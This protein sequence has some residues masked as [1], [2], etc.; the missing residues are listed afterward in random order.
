M[1]I[2]NYEDAL[3]SSLIEAIL[4]N[5]ND[6]G[7]TEKAV[8]NALRTLDLPEEDARM[9]VQGDPYNI[10]VLFDQWVNEEVMKAVDNPVFHNL[11]VHEKIKYLVSLKFKH[12]HPYKAAVSKGFSLFKSPRV[13]Q[14]SIVLMAENI[15]QIWYKAGDRST[16]FNYYTKRLVLTLVYMRVFVLWLRPTTTSDDIDTLVHD[17]LVSAYRIAKIKQSATDIVSSW[18]GLFRS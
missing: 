10:V 11:K 5:V 3:S 17:A 16:D 9:I 12:M 13:V 6:M 1:R 4:K 14:K 2:L 7:W 18:V 8:M 15:N